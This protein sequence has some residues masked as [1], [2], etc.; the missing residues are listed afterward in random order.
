[1]NKSFKELLELF[2]TTAQ[3][4]MTFAEA[5][6]DFP[7]DRINEFPPNVDYSPW[8]LLEHIRLTQVDIVDFML[9]PRYKEP[10]WPDEYW[11][12]KKIKATKAIWNKTI[13]GYKSDLARLVKMVNDPRVDLSAKVE[14][15]NGQTIIREIL[16]VIDHNS[17]HIGEFAI[18][19]QIMGTWQKKNSN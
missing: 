3:A 13:N 12:S 5:V 4:H 9:D 19:R 18:L 16:L 10:K 14:N 15:G 2:L 11:P 1:M 17:Y 7:M 8:M 6:A